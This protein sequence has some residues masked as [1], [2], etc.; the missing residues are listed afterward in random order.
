MQT[1]IYSLR[2]QKTKANAVALLEYIERHPGAGVLLTDAEWKAIRE[3][4]Q[5]VLG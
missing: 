4:I 1:L 5:V 2:C 3:L